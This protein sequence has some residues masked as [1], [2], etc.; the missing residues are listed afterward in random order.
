MLAN[1]YHVFPTEEQ[2]NT[3][4]NEISKK[5]LAI[6]NE[7]KITQKSKSEADDL[8]DDLPF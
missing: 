2:L 7:Y 4:A 3:F 6:I 1:Y 8:A 5:H